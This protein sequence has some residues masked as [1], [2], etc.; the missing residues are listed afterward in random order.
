MQNT[1][2][3]GREDVGRVEKRYDLGVV[4]VCISNYAK[5]ASIYDVQ[6]ETF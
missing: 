3:E 2:E 4:V 1:K 5:A 6:F